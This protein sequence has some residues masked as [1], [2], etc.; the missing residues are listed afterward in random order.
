MTYPLDILCRPWLGHRCSV[1][2]V[3]PAQSTSCCIACCSSLG[4]STHD[5]P[6]PNYK[7][8]DTLTNKRVGIISKIILLEEAINR[9]RT[10]FDWSGLSGV[11]MRLSGETLTNQKL[12]TVESGRPCDIF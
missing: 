8:Y 6:A 7:Q 1:L 11:N 12:E 9:L 10:Q 4:G 5:T 2:L 3:R